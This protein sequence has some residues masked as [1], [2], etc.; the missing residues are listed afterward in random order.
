MKR[1]WVGGLGKNL[2]SSSGVWGRGLA[3]NDF[4][5]VYIRKNT[6]VE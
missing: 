2:S 1:G 5:A 3:R 6:A 4:D